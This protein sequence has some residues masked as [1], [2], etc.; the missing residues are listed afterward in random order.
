MVNSLVIN[1]LKIVFKFFIIDNTNKSSIE[2]AK[3]FIGRALGI[4]IGYCPD[5]VLS[6]LGEMKYEIIDSFVKKL[7]QKNIIKS[8]SLDTWIIT[9]GINCGI[10]ELIGEAIDRDLNTNFLP[11]FGI[12][13]L[14][15]LALDFDDNRVSDEVWFQN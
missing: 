6:I 7:F 2:A 1:N 3:L 10:D 14:K 13:S 15:K 4:G 12:T 5:M 8:R 11:V 9:G